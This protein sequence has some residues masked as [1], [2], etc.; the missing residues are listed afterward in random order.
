MNERAAWG[1]LSAIL[2]VVLSVILGVSDWEVLS[3]GAC[4]CFGLTF[5]LVRGDDK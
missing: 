1:L 2:Y 5:A 3:L 4:G